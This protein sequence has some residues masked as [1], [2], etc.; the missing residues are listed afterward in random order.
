MVNLEPI[1]NRGR[2]DL[3]LMGEHGEPDVY[4]WEHSVRV[5]QTALRIA[6]LPSVAAH[7]PDEAA[8]VAAGLYHEAGWVARY[9][10]GEVGRL[11]VLNRQPTD[12]HREQAAEFMLEKLGDLLPPDSLDRAAIA[13]RTLNDRDIP[14]IEGQIVTEADNLDEFGVIALWPAVRRGALEGKGVRAVI[15]TW[16]RRKEY[17]FWTARLNDSFR[18]P[19]VREIAKARLERMERIMLE[20][21]EQ[22]NAADVNAGPR[23]RAAK[24]VA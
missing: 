12:N 2:L 4:L 8:V 5:A 9:A 6:Q 19:E 24:P 7:G 14:V 21:E 15:D 23:E 10:Q 18:F 20:L 22:Q 11:D 17:H 1:W 16:K 3:V 13:V